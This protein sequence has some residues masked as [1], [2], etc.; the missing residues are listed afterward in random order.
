MIVEPLAA[1]V[2]APADAGEL[3]VVRGL[4]FASRCE[5]HE[6]PF[7][8]AA[9]VGYVCPASA[10]DAADLADAIER[11]ARRPQR[12]ERLTAAVSEWV[13]ESF[14]PLGS[15]VVLEAEHACHA[16]RTAGGRGANV[17]TTRFRGT[18]RSDALLR[19][20]FLARLRR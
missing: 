1:A 4:R 2:G 16:V 8:G 9:H 11:L 19:A 20:E 14:Q 12:Q 18:L 10:F 15:A 7:V 3:V 17:I 5:S 13:A 6:L